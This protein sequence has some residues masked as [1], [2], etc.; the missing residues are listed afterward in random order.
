MTPPDYVSLSSILQESYQQVVSL[1]CNSLPFLTF[2]YL[3]FF[4]PIPLSLLP[5]LRKEK[6]EKLMKSVSIER[7]EEMRRVG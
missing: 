3:S 2:Y 4:R 5:F 1:L 7:G 6:E